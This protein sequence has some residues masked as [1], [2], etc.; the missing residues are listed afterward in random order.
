MLGDISLMTSTS[1]CISENLVTNCFFA[2]KWK[3]GH[4]CTKLLDVSIQCYHVSI[5]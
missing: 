2:I 4:F 3:K 5:K 1:S